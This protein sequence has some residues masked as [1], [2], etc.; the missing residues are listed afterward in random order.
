MEFRDTLDRLLAGQSLSEEQAGDAIS[1]VMKG[2]LTPSQIGAL[3]TAFHAKGETVEE[4]VG[5]AK[6]MRA[7]AETI[8]SHHTGIVDTCGTGGDKSGTFNISTTAA[9]VVAGAGVPLAK[10]GNRSATS[11]C[12]SIDLFERLGVNVMMP[13]QAM[14]RCLNETGMTVLF[15]RVVHPAMKHAAPVR[16]ELGIRTIFNFLGPL[17]NPSAPNYQLVGISNE[18]FLSIYA[19]CLQKLG[20]QKA[21]VVSGS[22]GLDE[23]TLTGM[24]KVLE[25]TQES[26]RAF[27]ISPKDAQLP[28]CA[29]EDLKGGTPEENEKIT[30]N[31]LSGKEQGAKRSAVLLNAGAALHIAERASSL[32]EGVEMAADA[33]DSGKPSEVLDKLI[34]ISNEGT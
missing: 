16:S 1:S 20:I 21:W 4:I 10:H 11:Q 8:S 32:K 18:Q 25:V 28:L 33:L 5:A 19:N 3:L 15:A 29:L 34:S 24:T 9:L 12:G 7:H 22:D 2:S 30:R 6:A 17:T 26:I 27:E 13:A 14:C 31:V 23:I